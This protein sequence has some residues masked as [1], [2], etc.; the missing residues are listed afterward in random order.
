[1]GKGS[2]GRKESKA[3]MSPRGMRIIKRNADGSMLVC[4][5]LGNKFREFEGNLIEL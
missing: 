3:K 4:D 5:R 2:G 1:M